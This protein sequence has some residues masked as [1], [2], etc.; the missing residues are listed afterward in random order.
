MPM[1]D[2][3][4]QRSDNLHN[5]TLV[6]SVHSGEIDSLKYICSW[7]PHR[8]NDLHSVVDVMKR[9]GGNLD[10]HKVNHLRNSLFYCMYLKKCE[11]NA[12][13]FKQNYTLKL[14]I[15]F[16]MAFT[17]YFSWNRVKARFS[18][19]PPKMFFN[20]DYSKEKV[21]RAKINSPSEIRIFDN[22]LTV[23]GGRYQ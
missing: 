1:V 16:K 7:V 23:I 14:F 4:S 6:I 2:H 18:R 9:F 11:N 19:F 8:A 5:I 20:I 13:I 15:A 3:S 17:C 12:T 10:F 22:W 21:T